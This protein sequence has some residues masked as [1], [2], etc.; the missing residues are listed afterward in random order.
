MIPN[1]YRVARRHGAT[2][3]VAL[4]VHRLLFYRPRVTTE[5]VHIM[6]GVVEANWG[7]NMVRRWLKEHSRIVT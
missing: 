2:A 1:V 4:A 7:R 5:L 6:V 3:D